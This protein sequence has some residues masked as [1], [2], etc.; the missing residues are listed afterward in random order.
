MMKLVKIHL[1]IIYFIQ[2]VYYYTCKSTYL[3]IPHFIASFCEVE[4]FE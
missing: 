4:W 3:I 2:Q 1:N